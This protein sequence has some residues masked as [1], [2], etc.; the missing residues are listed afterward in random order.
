MPSKFKFDRK[1]DNGKID[2]DRLTCGNAAKRAYFA[3]HCCQCGIAANAA[4]P[5]MGPWAPMG[6]RGPQMWHL[7]V[8]AMPPINYN[9]DKIGLAIACQTQDASHDNATLSI[10]VCGNAA[11]VWRQCRNPNRVK[12]AQCGISC[13]YFCMICY[14]IFL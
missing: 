6:P 11:R 1:C 10:R 3:V 14:G 12:L 13:V 9:S 8:F 2:S 5:P 4:L 7:H